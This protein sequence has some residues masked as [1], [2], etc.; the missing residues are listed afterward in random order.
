MQSEDGILILSFHQKKV[1]EKQSW[2]MW[3]LYAAFVLIWEGTGA[4]DE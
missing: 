2:R 1:I 3:F 4:P